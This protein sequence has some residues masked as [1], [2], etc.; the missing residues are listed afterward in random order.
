MKPCR[1]NVGEVGRD[2][3]LALLEPPELVVHTVVV[4]PPLV[5]YALRPA[6]GDKCRE[7]ERMNC[8]SHR[9]VI[10]YPESVSRSASC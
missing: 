5:V 2:G 8:P 4:N 7:Q 6:L 10:S 9:L 3:L 1:G